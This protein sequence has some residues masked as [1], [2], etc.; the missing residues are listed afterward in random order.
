MLAPIAP[1]SPA[2]K[3]GLVPKYNTANS[4]RLLLISDALKRSLAEGPGALRFLFSILL[5]AGNNKFVVK[6]GE[7]LHLSRNR[8]RA[9]G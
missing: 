7:I 8:L 5:D 3:F 2:A 9:K 1:F 4:M 6:N